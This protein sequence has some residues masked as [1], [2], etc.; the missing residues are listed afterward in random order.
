MKRVVVCHQSHVGHLTF[1][2]FIPYLV[3]TW[4]FYNRKKND[5]SLKNYMF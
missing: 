1:E 2:Y 3:G 5:S 4:F